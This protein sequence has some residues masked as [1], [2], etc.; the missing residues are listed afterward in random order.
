MIFESDSLSVHE[1]LCFNSQAASN[2]EKVAAAAA[3]PKAQR[4]EAAKAALPALPRRTG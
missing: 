1:T 3:G 2:Q 4:A